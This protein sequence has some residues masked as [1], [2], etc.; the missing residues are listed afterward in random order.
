MG[1]FDL[2]VLF[3]GFEV[4]FERLE[5]VQQC[6]ASLKEIRGGG[7]WGLRVAIGVYLGHD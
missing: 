5:F 6:L 1:D 7:W 4:F 3:A 2:M